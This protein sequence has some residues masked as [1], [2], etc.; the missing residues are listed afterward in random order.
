LADG[1]SSLLLLLQGPV[2]SWARDPDYGEFADKAPPR[3]L[4]WWREFCSRVAERYGKV[5]DFYE[6]W[7]EV[8]F[9]RDGEAMR[10]YNVYHFGG[11]AETDYLPLLQ[12]AYEAIKEKDPTALVVCGDMITTNNPDPKAGTGLFALLFDE[13]GRPGQDISLKVESTG[14]IVAERPMYFNYMGS[15]DGGHD[16]VGA[17]QPATQWYFAEGCTRRSFDMWL[18]LQNPHSKQIQVTATY[19]F[20]PGQ[21]ANVEKTY[22]LSPTS[23]FTVKVDD[24]VGEEKDV[25]VK[26]TSSDPF[27]AERPMYFH[28]KDRWTG[29]HCVVG[30]TSASREWYFAEGCTRPG[31]E[32]WLCLQN[33]QDH[34]VRVR[35]RYLCGDGYNEEKVISIPARS[36]YSVAVHEPREGIGIQDS[37]RGDVSIQVLAENGDIVAERPMYFNYG[38]AWTGGHCVV[39]TTGK[40]GNWYFAEGCTRRSFDMWLCLQNPHSKQIQVTAT[41]MFGP[42]QGANVEKTYTLSP[43]SRFTVKV[44]DEVGEEKDVSVK[45]T[46][47]DPFIAERPMYFHYNWKWTGGHCVMGALQPAGTWYFAEGC[48]GYNIEQYLCLQNPQSSAVEAT[49]T[50]M[51]KKGEVLRRKVTLPARSR[52]TI[53]VNRY[54]GFVGSCDMV[55]VHPYKMPNNWGPYYA[56]VVN[57]L[58]SRGVPHEAVVTEVGWPHYS[59]KQPTA[60]SEQQ[61]ADALLEWGM[62]GLINHGA[63]KIWIYK[64]MDEAPGTSWDYCYYGLF[65]YYGRPLKAWNSYKYWQ[66][67]SGIFPD[68]PRL[69]G[70]L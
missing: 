16:V 67:Q 43:T 22:T 61:Q 55:A 66:L 49:L 47:S 52:T 5:V 45:L 18:C 32:T 54:I 9:D 27:I 31:F 62:R 65:D 56:N 46:S 53:Y 4:S 10:N 35:L 17:L 2:P 15:W 3:D 69:P 8:G 23:R 36:R 44:D 58:R 14:D 29:G 13:V 25:S 57:V 41:Y 63:R 40:A 64:G 38:G 19:M 24:E 37:R 20:G 70:S 1:S 50:F 28:Y 48:H 59:D 68:Y 26:L 30:A 7:N 33:P 34:G 51:M 60:F 21:G 39:G 42:G 6:I 12:L 11:Q